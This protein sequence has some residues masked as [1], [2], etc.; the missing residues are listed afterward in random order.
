MSVKRFLVVLLIVLV[1]MGLMVPAVLAD[2]GGEPNANACFGQFRALG[3]HMTK[4]F[5]GSLGWL[6]T[7]YFDDLP[8][9]GTVH[10]LKDGLEVNGMRACFG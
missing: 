6:I 7:V 9:A 2:A 4:A 5:G 8:Q 10:D 3:A 1:V